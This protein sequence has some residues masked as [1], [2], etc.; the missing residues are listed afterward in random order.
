MI[1]CNTL[2][3]IKDN[4]MN[5]AQYFEIVNELFSKL[6][7]NQKPLIRFNI[8]DDYKKGSIH[9]TLNML[10]ENGFYINKIQE[11]I[12]ETFGNTKLEFITYDI[13]TQPI[14][15]YKHIGSLSETM[16]VRAAS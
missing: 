2:L 3:T 9:H 11:S 1:N 7:K 14:D 8:R 15:E 4:L 5:N 6:M 13:S 10:V 16:F 12:I